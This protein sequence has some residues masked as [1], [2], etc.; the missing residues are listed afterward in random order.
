MRAGARV[1]PDPDAK[2][3]DLERA[4]L[5]NLLDLDNLAGGALQL[6]EAAHKVPEAALGNGCVM[7]VPVPRKVEEKED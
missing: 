2:V 7:S 6:G 3:L 5:E 1:V 4:L